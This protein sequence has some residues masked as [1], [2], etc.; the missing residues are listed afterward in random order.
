MENFSSFNIISFIPR[1]NN[2][3]VDSLAL[4]VS[5]SN[6]YDVQIKTYFQVE[7][8]FRPSV[9]DNLEYLKVFENDEQME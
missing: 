5:L 4:V 2:Q 8:V 1:D 9:P 6:P 7:R 3:R